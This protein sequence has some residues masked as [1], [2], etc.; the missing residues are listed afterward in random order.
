[1]GGDCDTCDNATH[2]AMLP[3]PPY[4]AHTERKAPGL[5]QAEAR[6]PYG[7]CRHVAL[8]YVSH[9]ADMMLRRKG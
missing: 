2:E 4:L 1:M 5:R 9:L 7:S 6:S 8:I 3:A